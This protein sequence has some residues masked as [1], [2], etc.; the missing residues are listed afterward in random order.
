MVRFITTVYRL[1]HFEFFCLNVY[2]V[3][4]LRKRKR[5]NVKVLTVLFYY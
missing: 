1:R 5:N 3:A 2:C 4:A